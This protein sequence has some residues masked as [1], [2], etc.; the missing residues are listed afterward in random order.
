MSSDDLSNCMYNYINQNNWLVEI[1]YKCCFDSKTLTMTLSG[2]PNKDK[3][4]PDVNAP[5]A[6][7]AAIL[8]QFPSADLGGHK[9]YPSSTLDKNGLT[10]LLLQCELTCDS[11]SPQDV[12]KNI[13]AYLNQSGWLGKPVTNCSS[14]KFDLTLEIVGK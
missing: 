5:V 3:D 10:H 8:K 13:M 4:E 7:L 1:N 14:K 12:C 6:A 11:P 9:C 2:P